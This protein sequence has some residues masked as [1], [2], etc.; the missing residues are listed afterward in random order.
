MF[1]IST[2]I[3][4]TL[5]EDSIFISYLFERMDGLCQHQTFSYISCINYNDIVRKKNYFFRLVEVNTKL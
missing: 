5:N 3:S 2:D 1:F 4:L